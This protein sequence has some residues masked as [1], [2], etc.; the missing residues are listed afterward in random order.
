[1]APGFGVRLRSAREQHGI[2]LSG[3]AR[4]TKI[5]LSLLEALERDDVSQW[6]RGIFGRSHLRAYAQAIGLDPDKVV[7]EFL[8]VHPDPDEEIPAILEVVQR[9]SAEPANRSPRTRIRF[10]FDSA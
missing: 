4:Q 10:L 1:M 6:P 2:A 7:V 8:E 3:I 5:K 9:G